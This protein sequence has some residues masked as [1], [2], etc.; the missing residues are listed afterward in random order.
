MKRVRLKAI[1]VLSSAAVV[2]ALAPEPAAAD[3]NSNLHLH[4]FVDPLQLT[5]TPNIGLSLAVDK[6]SAIP[7]DKLIYTAVV[8]NPT[9]GFGMGGYFNAS[10]TA[11]ADATV[12]YY[13]DELEYC[14]SGFDCGSGAS[15]NH[16]IP[17]ATFENGQ[18]G[19][20]P[21]TLPQIHT[22]MTLAVQPVSRTGVTYP[23]S[24][25][26]VLGTVIKP[27]AMATWTY[28]AKVTFTPAQL[29]V[30]SDPTKATYIRNV[31]HLEMT[32]RNLGAAQ[33]ATDPEVFTNPF[34]STASPGAI[35]NITVTFTLPDGST[36]AV[37]SA[38]VPGLGLLSSGATAIAT[39]TYTVPAP[40]PRAGGE[41]E[42]DYAARLAGLDGKALTA[43]AVASGTGFSG[44]VY[45]TSPTVTTVEG[46]PIVTVAKSGPASVDAGATETNPLALTNIGSAA[47]SSLSVVDTVPGGAHGIVSGVPSTL[48]SG[49]SAAA[50][51]AFAV[52]SD[53]A[54]GNLT[55]TAAV[56]WKDANGNAY[57]SFT[58]SFT[59][60]VRNPLVGG[61]LT[62]AP[63][64]AGPNTVGTTQALTATLVDRNG[65]P[66][67]GKTVTLAV[68]GANPTTLSATT[69]ASGDATFTY[70][71]A[72]AGTDV[73][74][75]TFTFGS[76][77][78]TSN[79]SSISWGRPLQPVSA[80]IVSGN[81][82][83]NPNN[84]CTFDVGPGSTALWAQDFPDILFNPPTTAVPHNISNV[85]T[86]TRPFTDLTVDVNGNY[87][88]Q[89]VAQGNGWQAGSDSAVPDRSLVNFFAEF[90][91]TF[92]VNAPG[93]L[94]FTV[95]HD[96][97]YILGVGGGATRLNG[98]FEGNPPATTP[99]NGYP[100]VAAFNQGVSG[101]SHSGIDT[102][103]F[104]AAGTYPYELDY[105]E[106]G[107]GELFLVLE[108][109]KFVAQTDPL[110]VYVGYADGLRPG[111]SIFP[112]PWAGSPNV[113]FVGGGCC[114]NGAIRFD[115]NGTD[116]ITFDLITVDIGPFHYDLWTPLLPDGTRTSITLPPGQILILTGTSGEN[117]DTSDTTGG[118]NQSNFIPAVRITRQGVT[119]TFN[120]TTQVLNTGGVDQATCT[121]GNESRAWTRI[122]GG[123]TAINVPLPPG[124]SLDISPFKV[125]NATVGQDQKLT[126]SAMDGA[127]NPVA[128]LPVRLQVVGANTQSL[129]ATT[130]DTGLATFHYVGYTAGTD[131]IQAT[132]FVG[133][134]REVSNVGS[135]QWVLP[136]GGGPGS[137]PPPPAITS[138]LPADGTVVTKPVTVNA[139]IVPPPGETIVSWRLFY[140]ALDPG[141]LVQFGSGTG[142][143]PDPLGTFDPT[144]LPNDTYAITVEATASN[145]GVQDVTSTVVVFGNLKLGRYVTTYQDLSVPVNGFQMEVRRTHDSFDKSAG[146][147]GVGWRVSL[148]NFRVAPNHV[149]GAGGWTMFNKQCFIGLCLTGYKNSAPR[150]VTVTFPDQHTEVF[151]FTPLG[152]TNIFWDCTPQFTARASAGTTSKLE[153]V[154]DTACSYTGDGNLYGSNGPYSP[155]RFRLT[156][157]DGMV[158][159][160]DAAQGLISQTDRNGNALT[161]DGSGVHASSGG[162]ITYTRDAG[163]RITKLTG[164]AGETATYAYSS[165]ND[166]AQSVDT[167]GVTTA[168]AYDSSHNLI[169]ASGGS[170]PL[171]SFHYDSS[172][173][174]TAVTDALGNV[175]SV[176]SDV[177]GQQQTVTDPLGLLTTIYT[178]DDLGDIVRIDRVSGG[179]TLTSRATYDSLGHVLSRTDALSHTW[180]GAYDTSG[181][182]L[183][184]N[185]PGGGA[186][187]LT[188][189]A[190]GAPLAVRDAAGHQS[191]MEYDPSGNLVT[192]TD[193]AGGVQHLTYDSA[194]NRTSLTDASGNRS[195]FTFDSAGH[196]T[197]ITDPLGHTTSFTYDA[198][199][200]LTGRTDAAGNLASYAYD[201]AAH[202]TS[203]TDAL[204]GRWTYTYAAFGLVATV[205]D[206]AGAA[207]AYG[208]DGNHYLTSVTD[209]LGHV[210]AYAYDADGRLVR[211][212]DPAGGTST[213]AYDG[214]G[215]LASTTDPTGRATSFAYDAAGRLTSKTLPNGGVYSYTYDANNRQTALT[216]PLGRTTR[217]GY[218]SL[219]HLTTLTDPS[220]ATYNYSFDALGRQV[221]ATDPLGRT[222]SRAYDAVGNV[223]S[224]T[225]PLGRVTHFAYDGAGNQLSTTDPA[226]A[227]TR[228][229]YDAVDQLVS[230]SDPL[231][232]V[233]TSTYDAAGRLASTTLPAGDTYRYSYDAVGRLTSAVDPVGGSTSLSYD[234]IGRRISSTDPNGN[235][236]RFT[237]DGAGRQATI[238]DALGGVATSRY[239]AAG[240]LTSVTNPR[241]DTRTLS[242][243]QLG[244]IASVTDPAGRS[245]TFTYDPAGQLSSTTDPRGVTVNFAY[246][247]AG[248]LTRTAF[249]GGDVTS[250]YDTAGER[251]SMTDGTGTTRFGFDAAGQV[252]SVAAP[253]GT[254]SYAYD[255]AGRRA[256]MTA[257]LRGAI[258]YTYDAAGQLATM[259]DWTGGIFRFG[260]TADGRLSSLAGP[261]GVTSTY[262]YD[263]A[264]RLTAIDHSTP[265]GSIGHFTY[266]LDADGNP[267]SV[268]STAGTERYSLDALNRLTGVTYA[269][270]DVTNYTYDAAGNR[271]SRSD[272]GVTTSYAYDF[273]G[274]LTSAGTTGFTYDVAG[275]VT[276]AGSSTYTWDW[277]GRLSTATVGGV[278]ST[279][280]YDGD[281]LRVGSQTGGSSAAYLW[282]RMGADPTVID[283][284]T[285]GFAHAAGRVIEQSGAGSGG[286]AFP[287][288]DGLGSTRAIVDSTG[289]VAGSADYDV[290]GSV[291]AKTGVATVFGFTGEQS[292]PT[293]LLFLRSRYYDPTTGRFLSA[294]SVQPNAPG[295]Q[296][297]NL[298]SYVANNPATNT[299]PSGHEVV[300]YAFL[301]RVWPAI[302]AGAVF[303]FRVALVVLLIKLLSVLLEP[304]LKE[305]E[306]DID[307]AAR[308]I[309]EK[310]MGQQEP[311]PQP[312]PKVC[313]DTTCD[314][315]PPVQPTPT[316]RRCVAGAEAVP[317]LEARAESIRNVEAGT[318]AASGRAVADL[319]VRKYIDQTCL[320]IVGAGAQD[321]T[322]RQKTA[323]GG[324]VD[325]TA[326]V[327]T[328][329]KRHAE[330]TVLDAAS[331]YGVPLALGVDREICT[332]ES[333][334]YDTCRLDIS[335]S[336]GVITTDQR[337]AYWPANQ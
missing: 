36:A 258:G 22:G 119:T 53:Q 15:T 148:A 240:Q 87:N 306:R 166:L 196:N 230:V 223:L 311:E 50:S 71:G 28:L 146:D 195:T 332:E 109:A 37:G 253:A 254:V 9:A 34:T 324:Q 221:V 100:V 126:V 58:S 203:V 16:W 27:K 136:G 105:S 29:A 189:D 298:Y 276:S 293:G 115:N 157:I 88:G 296:G 239:D 285:R 147:F 233:T 302:V 91:G 215:R 151:D 263:A 66:L 270:G 299:D 187:T 249:P 234:A 156:T 69:S 86:F 131:S 271:L 123:G 165:S 101:G 211:W 323:V 247:A 78:L 30:L 171:Q 248:R 183:S 95:L 228:Y 218:D 319:R 173:R 329:P 231:G 38:Q 192:F 318:P 43:S 114:D 153:P 47:A 170:Q 44:P 188:Y 75:A 116:P 237:Y 162:S 198:S 334:R 67:G 303:A 143:P 202:V 33:P 260:Y 287:L 158:L 79:T 313:R 138:P 117:F 297:F 177:A 229:S 325:P 94:S 89:I 241:G 305:A 23:T 160:L 14:G 283:D 265:S 61:R 64:T 84:S 121:G 111:G 40:G 210:T 213:Y 214:F 219:G 81:F 182:L 120:D 159:V 180:T 60:V 186:T 257:P 273:A 290:F 96:D 155:K 90:T 193:A 169:S 12:K 286:A 245:T 73:A 284:G 207:T 235:V 97:G 65:N 314:I 93:D 261:E 288:A 326:V 20:V 281:G 178:M 259:T 200:R 212:T 31:L 55:D 331:Q 312:T 130:L 142:T 320:D 62:L 76:V 1:A 8:S 243:D 106:C 176:S 129:D 269:N 92:S 113:I 13:W 191:T 133:G 220:G 70:T 107:A 18:P 217:F 135:V 274:R 301:S 99:F 51:A 201:S 174:L 251:T 6:A 74:Q 17:V 294:D 145:G 185:R 68:T 21:I 122:G 144:V 197:S 227:T 330:I 54:E 42:H 266:T 225:D 264:D 103:H 206:P 300:P 321:L 179:T 82:F 337:G 316:P 304:E 39:T 149:L 163:G 168:Y 104:P 127:G 164:P 2:L 141:P 335:A 208:Y 4:K 108:S 292:D 124:A 282:D 309:F 132:A 48:A 236:T 172:G 80:G 134:L 161:V 322:S 204:G 7:G 72:N 112:F 267:T 52:P 280:T 85:N 11:S 256:S 41:T 238:T 317:G 262:T 216:D 35:H 310:I 209:A 205:T 175:T 77:T 252:T 25:D 199:G 140:Q 277:A 10:S 275:N 336:G 181:N 98:D 110:S 57:G 328:L 250:A 152:G 289:S 49:G 128:N 3:G 291:R 137:G 224:T 307:Q 279:Y 59:T 244:N 226:G 255:A 295:T 45:A 5:I 102:I 278:T 327:A 125:V 308:A 46:V 268:T 222:S 315:V 184:L 56:T 83:R 24:G 333:P 139:T 167:N 118:C 19:Y 194:G 242:Y 32:V 150:S 190:S 272:N 154:D 26:L 246:D 63:I 232:R